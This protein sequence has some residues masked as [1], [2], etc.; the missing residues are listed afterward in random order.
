MF[1]LHND[2]YNII[3]RI[4]LNEDNWLLVFT[5]YKC[6]GTI[7]VSLHGFLKSKQRSDQSQVSQTCL[8]K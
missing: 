8:A 4:F 3:N 2:C 6:K 7:R 5:P 1:V